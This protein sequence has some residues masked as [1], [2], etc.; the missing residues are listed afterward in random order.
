[1]DSRSEVL[2]S[3]NPLSLLPSEGRP[4]ACLGI[5]KRLYRA[6][7]FFCTK[8]W[9]SFVPG[10]GFF[11]VPGFGRFKKGPESITFWCL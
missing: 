6:L 8:G 2:R 4:K 3:I 5:Y 10:L 11:F 7:D 9:I 1:M